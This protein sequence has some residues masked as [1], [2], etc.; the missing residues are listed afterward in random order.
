MDV[1]IRKISLSQVYQHDTVYQWA[2]HPQM[3]L[4]SLKCLKVFVAVKLFPCII[5]SYILEKL[6]K[7]S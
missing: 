2:F 3:L 7:I 1:S 5:I 6:I 4:V